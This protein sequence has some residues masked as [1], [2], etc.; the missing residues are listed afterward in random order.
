MKNLKVPREVFINVH[1]QVLSELRDSVKLNSDYMSMSVVPTVRYNR[2]R[3]AIESKLSSHVY[4]VP[5]LPVL[6]GEWAGCTSRKAI[7][8]E[9]A[10]GMRAQEFLP[11]DEPLQ[12]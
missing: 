1:A 9:E 8:G 3:D 4:P 11:Q 12:E 10:T 2:A 5:V 7:K 6:R